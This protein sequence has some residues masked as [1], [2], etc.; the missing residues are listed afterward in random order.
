M[1]YSSRRGESRETGSGGGE[2]SADLG[3]CTTSTSCSSLA[4]SPNL[5]KDP[6]VPSMD[7]KRIP[8]DVAG[9]AGTCGFGGREG[10]LRPVVAATGDPADAEVDDAPEGEGGT[11]RAL[12][13]SEEADSGGE[14]GAGARGRITSSSLL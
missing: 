4:A 11:A 10:V 13:L 5:R 9:R 8:I 1:R 2:G 12:P 6:S 7:G 14:G 3:S